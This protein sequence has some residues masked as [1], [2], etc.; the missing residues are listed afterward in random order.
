MQSGYTTVH[1]PCSHYHV[2]YQRQLHHFTVIHKSSPVASWDSTVSI[3]LCTHQNLPGM[4]I[5]VLFASFMST[6]NL[7]IAYYFSHILF[8]TNY[9]LKR[10]QMHPLC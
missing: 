1:S 5:R 6:V 9:S 3:I 4:G 7:D 8:F 10:F 2:T